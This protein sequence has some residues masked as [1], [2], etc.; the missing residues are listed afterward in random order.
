MEI[1]EIIV[2]EILSYILP[3][4]VSLNY[5]LQSISGKL[6]YQI[7]IYHSLMVTSSLD[8]LNKSSKRKEIRIKKEKVEVLQQTM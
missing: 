6:I 7:Y 1:L 2:M 8:A 5:L 4:L 3:P